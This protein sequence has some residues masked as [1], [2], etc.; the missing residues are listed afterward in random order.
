MGHR[1]DQSIAAWQAHAGLILPTLDEANLLLS[2]QEAAFKLIKVIGL[3]ISGI[4]DGDSLWHG[5]D[6]VYGLLAQVQQTCEQIM[7]MRSSN[8]P[9]SSTAAATTLDKAQTDYRVAWSNRD[10]IR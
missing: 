4:R 10:A 1:T 9:G 7:K 2:L 8:T 3:E 5:S 6:P